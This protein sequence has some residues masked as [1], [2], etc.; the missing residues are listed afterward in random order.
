MRREKAFYRG[1]EVSFL[2]HLDGRTA[3][4]TVYKSLHRVWVTDKAV[5]IEEAYTFIDNLLRK[6]RKEKP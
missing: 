3:L 5:S 1:Y 6:E 4:L 2:P